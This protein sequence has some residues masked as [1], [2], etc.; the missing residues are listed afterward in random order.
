M[1]PPRTAGTKSTT[2]L[3]SVTPKPQTA[4]PWL[5]AFLA[6]AGLVELAREPLQALQRW[7][8]QRAIKEVAPPTALEVLDSVP[9]DSGARLSAAER[10][11]GV[12]AT[13]LPKGPSGEAAR[14]RHQALI[15]R[16]HR[17][18]FAGDPAENCIEEIRSFVREVE[19]GV[20]G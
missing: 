10:A 3:P 14:Q 12:V 11:L 15:E 18:R 8:S 6:L 20:T 9:A 19:Q 17:V 13:L 5:L 2:C 1:T 4:W 7:R 16:L